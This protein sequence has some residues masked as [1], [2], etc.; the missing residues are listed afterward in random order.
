MPKQSPE[1]LYV[2]KPSTK[3]LWR[4]YRVYADRLELE[5]VPWGLVRVPFEDIKAVEVRPSGVVFDAIRGDYGLL[6]LM[7]TVKLDL[8]DLHEHVA[9]EKSGF[10]KQFRLTPDD[11][12]QFKRVV[13]AALA[14]F[15]KA[16]E[17]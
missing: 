3:N 1:P 11:P 14:A 5:T 13:D 10:W 12:A 2:S 16:G 8:A 6:E 17:R 15:R 7:R 9:V 4:E